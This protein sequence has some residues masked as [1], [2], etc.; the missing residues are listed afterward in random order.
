MEIASQ[1][2][3]GARANHQAALSIDVLSGS[4]SRSIFLIPQCADSWRRRDRFGDFPLPR[5][6][7]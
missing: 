4:I 2:G 7:V 6:R 3:N 5:G 1:D